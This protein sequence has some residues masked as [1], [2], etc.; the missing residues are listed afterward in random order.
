MYRLT[1]C[2]PSLRSSLHS[3]PMINLV[4]KCLLTA[5]VRLTWKLDPLPA[6]TNHY[7]FIYYALTSLVD[8]VESQTAQRTLSAALTCVMRL[9]GS[10]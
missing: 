10:D 7:I 8:S 9:R 1:S 3:V 2:V 4:L 6:Q 5:G